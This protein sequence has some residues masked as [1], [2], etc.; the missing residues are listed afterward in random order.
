MIK[1]KACL[2]KNKFKLLPYEI[3]FR[4]YPLRANETSQ[5]KNHPPSV[6]LEGEIKKKFHL[7]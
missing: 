5:L 4:P 7:D 1:I 6:R 2:G 3:L